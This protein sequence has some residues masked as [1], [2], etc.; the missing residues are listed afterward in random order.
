MQT[1]RRNQ[2]QKEAEVAGGDR[3]EFLRGQSRP[4]HGPSN[5]YVP[6]GVRALDYQFCSDLGMLAVLTAWS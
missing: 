1:L 2:E 3:A 6:G 4:Q 5:F